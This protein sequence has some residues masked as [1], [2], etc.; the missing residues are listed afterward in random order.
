MNSA[1]ETSEEL[2][3]IVLCY[4]SMGLSLGDSPRKIEMTYNHLSREWKTNLSS[5]VEQIREEARNSIRLIDEMYERI[6]ESVTYQ[7]MLREQR[8]LDRLQGEA[9]PASIPNEQ[10]RVLKGGE[11]HC[12]KC[13][14]IV[15][16]QAH[17]CP[18]CRASFSPES[19]ETMD[20]IMASIK[21][22]SFG[23]IVLV[24]FLMAF[25]WLKYPGL[26]KE[27]LRLF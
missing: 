8:R 25:F 10:E 23:F 13:R 6:K 5:P 19:S 17:F 1:I 15:R 11:M 4:T 18:E 16:K 2:E 12:P 7:A 22:F 20:S 14:A 24:S 9:A 27:Y 3:D 21:I 26:M